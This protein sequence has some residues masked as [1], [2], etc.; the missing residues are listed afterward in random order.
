M[1]FKQIGR[2]QMSPKEKEMMLVKYNSNILQALINTP[3]EKFNKVT[4]AVESTYIEALRESR[5]K[6]II[7][8]FSKWKAK[9]LIKKFNRLY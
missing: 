4:G 8:Y 2:N 7:E 3:K 6:F 1:D 9:R 5:N